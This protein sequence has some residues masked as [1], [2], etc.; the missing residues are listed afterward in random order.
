MRYGPHS[1]LGSP[2]TYLSQTVALGYSAFCDLF[3]EEEWLGFEYANDLLF[4]YSDGFGSPVAAAQGMGYVQ[5]L[6]ARLMHTPIFVHNTTTNST[7]DNNPITM[8]LN[9]PIYVDATH[10]VVIAN[11]EDF[12][13][14]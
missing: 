5:E 2:W 13:R 8:P 9:Q 3:T 4:W 14:D 6:L 1:N 12:S 10:D 7:I 11:C